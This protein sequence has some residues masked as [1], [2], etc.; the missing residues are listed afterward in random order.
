MR[1][2]YIGLRRR[3]RP[4][5]FAS[6]PVVCGRKFCA[7]CG[8]WRLICD[9]RF[10]SGRPY[11]YC[12]GCERTRLREHFRNMTAEQRELRN[13]YARF[14]WDAMARAAGLPKRER[15]RSVV[16]RVEPVYLEPGPLIEALQAWGDSWLALVATSGVPERS[17][18][19]LVRG[20]SR[21]VRLDLADKLA[22]ALGIPLS[23][24][25]DPDTTQV[26]R[27]KPPRMAA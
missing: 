5:F 7:L 17:I 14:R 8:R 18:N 3:D 9:F 11:S 21:H 25:Y 13:E 2:A 20:E 1:P 16:D 27:G 6:N 26:A 22:N 23:L 4:A 24:I 19:R 12:Q 15:R 10:K